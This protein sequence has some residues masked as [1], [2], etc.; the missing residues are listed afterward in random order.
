LQQ[1][2]G[3]AKKDLDA[4]RTRRE[5]DQARVMQLTASLETAKLGSRE[6]QIAAAGQALRTQEAAL[7]GAEWNLSQ[8]S[9]SAPVSAQVTDIVFRPGDWVAAGTP[10]V[11]LLPPANVKV[12]SFV[13]QTIVGQIHTGDKAL[14]SVDGVEPPYE[15]R[16]SYIAPRAE[17]TPP[18]IYSQKMREKFVFL[19]ELKFAPEVAVK[20]HPGQPVDVRFP[21][22]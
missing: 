9:Q 4:A 13:S 5:R 22:P 8:K 10:V 2:K 17:Y 15:G 18:V 6:A 21:P 20:L 19:V 11:V 7:A 16:V 12:R 3:N 1:V 14:V